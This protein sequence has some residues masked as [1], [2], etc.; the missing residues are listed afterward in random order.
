[1]R[2]TADES[3]R[4]NKDPTVDSG[5]LRELFIP[6]PSPSLR[7]GFPAFETVRRDRDGLNPPGAGRLVGVNDIDRFRPVDYAQ[8]RLQLKQVF[9]YTDRN[10]QECDR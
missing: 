6:E 3:R 9:L 4:M 8:F 7:Q 2:R 5:R 10:D 1:M